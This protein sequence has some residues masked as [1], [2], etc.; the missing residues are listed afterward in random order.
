M[1]GQDVLKNAI[2]LIN[3]YKFKE[4]NYSIIDEVCGSNNIFKNEL[5]SNSKKILHFVWIGI[6][7][8]KALLYLSVWA[9]HYPNYEV[10]LWIDSKYLYANIFKDKIED[11]RKNKK[12]IELLKTQELLYDEYQ[13]LRLKDNPLEQIIDKF[14]QQDFSK[15][16]DKL[17]I[18][19]ELVSKFN[20]LNIK[21]IREHK[22]IIP[23]EI[24]I[25]YEKEI[26]LRSNLAAA[27]DISRLCILKKFGGVYLDIDTLPCLEYVFKNSKVYENFEFYYNELI[28]IYKSQLYLEK[29]TKELNPNLAIENY[30]IKVELITGDN[31]KKEKI[32][33]YLESLK[34]DIKS[35]DIKKVEALPF[36]I[37]KN[38]LMIGTSKVK[39]NTF[40]N[41]VLVSEKNG[42]MVSI[43]LKEICKRYKYIS[44]K[45]YDRWESVE[46]YNK[47]YKNSYLDR[48]VGYRLDALADIPNTTVILTGPCM[49]LEVYLSLTYNIFKLDKNIDPRKIASLYQSSN[50]GITCRNLMTFTL[51][52]SKST[53]M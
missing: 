53:W 25:Y 51:E 43:I 8:E 49:I 14:F 39:L 35:H 29:Y 31:I 3:E 20:F 13:K 38:L 24:E 30:N 7:D 15:G 37:R 16:I 21:D 32:V 6:P 12:L 23:K 10:N 52:N 50:C 22:S 33:E 40:Y 48:L 4:I 36:I 5:Y 42:K 41:N 11:I 1:N 19:N 47:V 44:S 2:E 45:N 27:S 17:K 28:D 46:K 18:I 34:H 9:H 26:I